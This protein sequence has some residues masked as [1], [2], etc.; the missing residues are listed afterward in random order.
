MRSDSGSGLVFA[1][2]AS[3]PWRTKNGNYPFR[4]ATTRRG[5][6]I[7]KRE[8]VLGGINIDADRIAVPKLPAQN[9]P[10]QCIFDALL[11]HALQR[12]SPERR[13]IPFLRQQFYRRIRQT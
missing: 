1:M 5:A 12:P 4:L 13:I 8:L 2:A 6:R 10:S 3:M 11:N 9:F 7:R